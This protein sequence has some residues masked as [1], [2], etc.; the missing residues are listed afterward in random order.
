MNTS[1]KKE[2]LSIY[3]P[4]LAR[5]SIPKTKSL[6]EEQLRTGVTIQEQLI[7]L[8][9]TEW[10]PSKWQLYSWNTDVH[11][12][13]GHYLS[14]KNILAMEQ[15]CKYW[16][17]LGKNNPHTFK[18][19]YELPSKIW[20]TC[21]SNNILSALKRFQNHIKLEKAP[22]NHFKKSMISFQLKDFT[23]LKELSI[24]IGTIFQHNQ[25]TFSP[26]IAT[27]LNKLE[28]ILRNEGP[29][30][31][32]LEFPIFTS[33]TYLALYSGFRIEGSWTSI[34]FP[35][36]VHF[37]FILKEI[38]QGSNL[39]SYTRD[40]FSHLERHLP[41]LKTLEVVNE[42]MYSLDF[43]FK[44]TSFPTLENLSFKD[45]TLCYNR[46]CIVVHHKLPLNIINLDYDCGGL[47]NP[48]FYAH[49][50]NISWRIRGENIGRLAYPQ[51]ISCLQ[52]LVLQEI[53]LLP[54]ISLLA[55]LPFFEKI[56][57]IIIKGMELFQWKY[58]LQHL[59]YS[60][61]ANEENM[62]PRTTEIN[63]LDISESEKDVCP[64]L[65]DDQKNN[66]DLLSKDHP[67]YI[68]V[69]TLICSQ[70]QLKTLIEETKEL[71][72]FLSWKE[73]KIKN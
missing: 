14:L 2:D 26:H 31:P 9:Q 43:P 42:N 33:L 58:Y 44:E 11:L 5:L 53:Q 19:I 64:L 28:F 18:H 39:R 37:K 54:N 67:T 30:T 15:T 51:N 73:L 20:D 35:E 71:C 32:Y 56:D 68:H 69:N 47:I 45:T 48:A 23:K 13:V 22:I 46:K 65:N 29:Y 61:Y 1:D 38:H 63:K 21:S 6:L 3:F 17:S 25:Y 52:T 66:L 34:Y 27:H 24:F 12:I 60:E 4:Y 41:K 70:S 36:V 57:S 16:N 7:K 50:P 40:H 8:L 59:V 49:I 72:Q 62:D 10:K 55:S